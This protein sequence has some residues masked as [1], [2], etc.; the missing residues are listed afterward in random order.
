[1]ATHPSILDWRIP[2]TEEPRVLQLMGWQRVPG[3]SVFW[4]FSVPHLFSPDLS[5]PFCEIACRSSQDVLAL[6]SPPML[7]L[8]RV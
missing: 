6:L 7:S 8:S 1:M 3:V 4:A 2:R 5:L